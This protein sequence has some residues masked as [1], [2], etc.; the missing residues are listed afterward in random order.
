[1]KLCE[2]GLKFNMKL[3]ESGLYIKLR[4][5]GLNMK[6]RKSGLIMKLCAS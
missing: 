4:E 5:S 2:I 3:H 6:L 1:M